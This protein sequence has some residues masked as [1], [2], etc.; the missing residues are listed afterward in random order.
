[1]KKHTSRHY[2][3]RAKILRA[4]CIRLQRLG[5]MLAERKNEKS[6]TSDQWALWQAQSENFGF[7]CTAPARCL[8]ADPFL[9]AK[10]Q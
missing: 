6:Q 1:V 5:V 2:S 10:E 8:S 4:G 9:S 7:C 3:R